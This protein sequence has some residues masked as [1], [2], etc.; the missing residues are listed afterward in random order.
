LPG[1]EPRKTPLKVVEL[2]RPRQSEKLGMDQKFEGSARDYWGPGLSDMIV[3]Q[4]Q[5][6]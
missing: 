4:K 3:L 5:Y 1:A 6:Y 2:G